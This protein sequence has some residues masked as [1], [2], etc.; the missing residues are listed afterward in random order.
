M[1]NPQSWMSEECFIFSKAKKSLSDDVLLDWSRL[2]TNATRLLFHLASSSRVL[3]LSSVNKMHLK[4][5]QSY[6][7]SRR[8]ILAIIECSPASD[9]SELQRRC[10]PCQSRSN[11]SCPSHPFE[12]VRAC[13]VGIAQPSVAPY[14]PIDLHVDLQVQAFCIFWPIE[15]FCAAP[16]GQLRHWQRLDS[17]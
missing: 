12:R 1:G 17:S 5:N 8:E 16:D 7:C 9:V 15:H 11:C 2:T 14:L 4:H 6:D 13:Q 10:I 3:L